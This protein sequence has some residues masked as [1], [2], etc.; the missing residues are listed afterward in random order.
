MKTTTHHTPTYYRVRSVVR[1]LFV[2]TIATGAYLVGRE[3]VDSTLDYKCDGTSV[4]VASGDTLWSI[5][6]E[7]CEGHTG[8]AVYDLVGIYGT[9]LYAGQT[10]SLD[11]ERD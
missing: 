2:A 11:I 8:Q 6:Q 7:H 4:V 3:I 1:F 9:T 5:A 10:I